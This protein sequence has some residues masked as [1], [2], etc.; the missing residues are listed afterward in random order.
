MASVA[1]FESLPSTISCTGA[2]RPAAMSWAKVRGMTRP[3]RDVAAVDRPDH[4][5]DRCPT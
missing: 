4:L 2:V 1:V 5:R 3:T